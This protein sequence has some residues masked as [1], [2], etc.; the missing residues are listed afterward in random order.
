MNRRGLASVVSVVK[1]RSKG[2]FKM[3]MP[4]MLSITLYSGFIDLVDNMRLSCMHQAD[5][6]AYQKRV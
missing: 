5:N 1:E 4:A 6:N 3:M 2:W